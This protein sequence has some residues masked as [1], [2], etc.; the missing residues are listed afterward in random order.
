[1]WA[2]MLHDSY[3]CVFALCMRMHMQ[4]RLL[5]VKDAMIWH[6]LR[7][8]EEQGRRGAQV[9]AAYASELEVCLYYLILPNILIFY[10]N[11][12]IF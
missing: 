2:C 12:L 11:Y 9:A 3:T 1:M 8:R 4:V 7:E 6:L 5:G 10:L